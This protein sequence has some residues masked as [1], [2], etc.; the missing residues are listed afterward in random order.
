MRVL[1][2]YA[3]AKRKAD[4]SSYLCKEK[5][6]LLKMVEVEILRFKVR[7]DLMNKQRQKFF[8]AQV[9]RG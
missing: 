8:L 2:L 5:C 7:G 1:C 6:I 4:M 9:R 3:G